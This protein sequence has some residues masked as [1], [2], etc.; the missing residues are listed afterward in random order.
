MSNPPATFNLQLF[1]PARGAS[2]TIIPLLGVFGLLGVALGGLATGLLASP[3]LAGGYLVAVLGG[4]GW[5]GYRAYKK[6][7]IISAKVLLSDSAIEVVDHDN[8]QLLAVPY[9]AIS[10]YRYQSM[11]EAEEL[12]L[13]LTDT[14][15]VKIRSNNRLVTVGDFAGMVAAFE[16][17]QRQ[18]LAAAGALSVKR[19]KAFFEKPVSTVLLVVVTSLLILICWNVTHGSRPFSGSLIGA[20]GS[21]LTYLAGWL[22]AAKR[23]NAKD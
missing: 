14:Q 23:R 3:W 22:A 9:T 2:L 12:R 4:G 7:A 19:E 16:A 6:L 5:L 11:N 15:R 8:N 10:A 1:D 20:I 18:G 21:Y 17:H 13:T